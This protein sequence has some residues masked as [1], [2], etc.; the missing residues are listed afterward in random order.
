MRK[1]ALALTQ[2]CAVFILLSSSASAMNVNGPNGNNINGWFKDGFTVQIAYG[3][4]N[5]IG[6]GTAFQYTYTAGS[7]HEGTHHY[8]FVSDQFDNPY[9]SVDTSQPIPLAHNPACPPQST[10]PTYTMQK[11]FDASIDSQPPF[12]SINDPA[13]STSTAASSYT[14]SGT[15]SDMSSGVKMAQ[16]IV[17]GSNGP[18]AIVSGSSF[19]VTVPLQ[20]G[21]NSVQ[22]IAYDD[23]GHSATSN[24]VTIYSGSTI[25]GGGGTTGGGTT[26]G[27]GITSGGSSTSSTSGTS[28]SG[29]TS[30]GSSTTTAT[31][32]TS[33]VSG[34]PAPVKPQIVKFGQQQVLNIL[35]ANNTLSDPSDVQATT[36]LAGATGKTYDALI[37][38]IVILFLLCGFVIWRFRPIFAELDRDKSGLRKRIIIIV[39]LPS[40]LP[41]L[42]LGLLGYQQLSNS[43]KN[44]LSSQLEKAAQTSSLKLD[45]EFN[46][47]R[48]IITKTSSD[49]LQI[50]SQYQ[51]Q[52]DTL[53]LQQGSCDTLVKTDIPRGKYADVTGSDACLPF[54]TGFAQLA[55]S[56]GANVS[57][58]ENALNDGAALAQKNLNAQEDQR[59][60]ELL[61]SVKHYFPDLLELDIV[62]ASKNATIKATLP[63]TDNQSSLATSHADLLKQASGGYLA[64]FDNTTKT[65]QLILTYPVQSGTQTLGGAVAAFDTENRYFIPSVW[66]STPKPYSSDEVYFVTTAG[67]LITP[68]SGPLQLNSQIKSIASTS[69]GKIYNLK[70]ASQTLA[71]RVS[72]VANTNWVVAVGAPASSILAPLAGIQRTAILAIAGFLLLSALLGI[73]F[74]SGIASEIERLFRGALAFA[75]GELDYRIDLTSH[76]ELQSLGDTMDKMASDIKAAQNALIEKDKEFINIATHEL[77]A[78]MTSII[79]NLSMITEDGMGQVDDTARML[80]G[81]AY[82]G[83]V[84]LREIVTDML[85][86]ARLESGHAEFKPEALNIYDLTQSVVDMQTVPAQ[87]VSVALNY[88]L[89]G[90]V[91][92]VFADKN[93]LQII[94]SNFVSNAVKYNRPGGTVTITHKVDGDKLVTSIAD[95]GLGIPEDQKAHMFEKF[96]RVQN[97][98]R[99][100]IP[101]TGLGMHITKRYIE[102][103]GGQVWF[104]SEHGKGTTFYFSLP[105]ASTP[106]PKVVAPALSPAPAVVS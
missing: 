87:Q 83:T 42:G 80:I 45:R 22:M 103:M 82:T 37:T 46:I 85:D 69:S 100:T 43:V 78:P 74:V 60:N 2:F 81:Q 3:T 38:T 6:A 32:Q 88:H 91:P 96:F 58:Y 8:V 18:N 75:K 48:T 4:P 41:L 73:Y 12:I 33:G 44:S 99:A 1:I 64:L 15:V 29:A 97:R 30:S 59:V 34:T 79:G 93:K 10:A 61:G 24:T 67:E 25:S 56:S 102:A 53:T 70:L 90:V 51:A 21:S 16:A 40:L 26:T 5:C 54:L 35:D 72:P 62:D 65:R 20:Q 7:E 95:T 50:K 36:S 9:V 68:K 49:I 57:S 105:L 77:K 27:G 11:Q 23:V 13:N 52:R 17:N 92:Q 101:G 76:D 84:R 63:R 94:L 55:S 104:E 14:V 39:T 47:R 28:S 31:P 19:S 86:I 98:D 106:A 89:A 71:T 66:S